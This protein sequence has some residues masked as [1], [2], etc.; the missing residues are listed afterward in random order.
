MGPTPITLIYFTV[1]I[2]GTFL[3]HR[4]SKT[5]KMAM[6]GKVPTLSK[7]LGVAMCLFTF[8]L[9]VTTISRLKI[10]SVFIGILYNLIRIACSLLIMIFFMRL[11]NISQNYSMASLAGIACCVATIL[12]VGTDILKVLFKPVFES[13]YFY[14]NDLAN[15]FRNLSPLLMIAAAGILCGN[16]SRF[17]K[18]A[19]IACIIML[20][21]CIIGEVG[22]DLAAFFFEFETSIYIGIFMWLAPNVGWIILFFMFNIDKPAQKAIPTDIYNR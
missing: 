8:I 4:F 19:M 11:N 13:P 6:L 22:F 10:D 17:N 15:I 3:L 1:F 16:V 2:V 18:T 5:S 14:L 7:I 9:L 12:G 20:A 21:S